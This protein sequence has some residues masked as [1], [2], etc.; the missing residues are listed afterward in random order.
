MA[1]GGVF[2][3]QEA[4]VQRLLA[5]AP[6]IEWIG[7]DRVA[8]VAATHRLELIRTG[9]LP[10]GRFVVP[11]VPMLGTVWNFGAL[12]GQ[13]IEMRGARS[14]STLT[15]EGDRFTFETPCVVMEGSWL[16]SGVGDVTISPNRR[17]ARSCDPGS[18]GQSQTWTEAMQGRL[19][20]NSG[21]NGEILLAGGGHWM[22]GDMARRGSS[23]ASSL[24]GRY[25]VA[26]NSSGEQRSGAPPPELMLARNAYYVWDGCNHTEGLAIAFERQLFLHSSGLT[27]LATCRPG[28]E[29]AN[30][31]K[32]VLSEPRIGRIQSGLLLSSPTGTLRLRRTGDAPSGD[33]GVTSRL[34]SGMRF[35]FLGD[36]VGALAL[37]P[38]NRFR[39]TQPC[40]ETE[41]R[42][43]AAPRERD[44]AL[45]FG[46]EGVAE[47]CARDLAAQRLQRVFQGNV[48]LAIG[49]NR[50]IAMFVGRF[51]TARA[52]LEQ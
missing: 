17:T 12:D 9:P 20:Y 28:R 24:A 16:Q 52:R 40:G 6:Q 15:V 18:R 10:S 48:D 35:T 50:D 49:P 8:L 39:L 7:S 45:R 1:C 51:G 32:I 5:S 31:S 38:G 33:G 19:R 3:R 4:D 22:V 46:P 27:T 42:W 23:D 34:A 13:V 26:G 44:G 25:A 43:R 41:G 30:L 21:P 47:A 14:G 2:D 37:L 11:V 29:N 36:P